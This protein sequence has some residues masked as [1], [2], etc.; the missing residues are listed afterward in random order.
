MAAAVSAAA[1]RV[2]WGFFDVG[3][4]AA[5]AAALEA[6]RRMTG[7]QSCMFGLHLVQASTFNFF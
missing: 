7:V 5:A 4:A 6:E 1:D 2:K 3:A